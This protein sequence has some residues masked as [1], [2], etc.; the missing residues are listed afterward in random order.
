MELELRHLRALCAIA[1]AGSV[2]RAAA[3]L[4]YSQQAM[5]TQLQ[6][7]E[8]HFGRPLFERAVSGVELTPYDA[9]VLARARD[10]L[11][12][13]DAIGHRPTGDAP[14][15]RRTLRLAATNSPVLPGMADGLGVSIV[16]ATHRPI[17]GVLVKPLMGMPLWCR[18]LLAFGD[19]R[20]PE[21]LLQEHALRRSRDL[22]QWL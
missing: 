7:I 8:H 22:S 9:E 14:G 11:A 12:R 5:S 20:R 16:Q 17:P 4:G 18:Y 3:I 1:D 15:T 21:P 2:G 6:R 10:V 13:A 19:P